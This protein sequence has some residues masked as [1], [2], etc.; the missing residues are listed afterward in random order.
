MRFKQEEKMEIIRIVEQSE[1]GVKRTLT[2][3]GVSRSTFY[4]WYNRYLEEGYDGLVA[5]KPNRRDH[6]NKIPDQERTR[7]INL[8]L[9]HTEHSARGLAWLITDTLEW[10]ISESS[11]YRILKQAGLICPP[12]HDLIRAAD[13]Y[14]NKTQRVNE[15]WQT[16]F[17]YFKVIGWGWYYLS[18]IMDDYSRYIIHWELCKNMKRE[19][20]E[21]NVN[22]ALEKTGIPKN[23]RPKLLSDNGSCYIASELGAFMQDHGIKHIRGRAHHPQTQGKIERYHRSL[24]NVIKLDT[25]YF[26][27]QLKEQISAFID[28]YNNHRYHE[29]LDNM[30]PADVYFGRSKKIMNKR[31]Q[32]KIKTLKKRRQD[33]LDLK[34]QKMVS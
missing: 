28:H 32:T 12:T 19:D 22:R 24:K 31:K 6:W 1:L 21:R 3:L 14:T 10:F 27:E 34:L 13:E 33:Y 25:Y 2:N 29:S 18:T 23:Q 15:M 7:V 30:T 16:D 8:A 9:D 5:R 26:P 11:V 4:S 17:T 20:V